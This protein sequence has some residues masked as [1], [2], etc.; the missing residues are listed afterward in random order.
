MNIVPFVEYPRSRVTRHMCGHIHGHITPHSKP[1]QFAP[2]T[3]LCLQ[4][5]SSFVPQKHVSLASLC[6]CY[7]ARHPR[8][9]MPRKRT[10]YHHKQLRTCA[11]LG[12]FR[13]VHRSTFAAGHIIC[14]LFPLPPCVMR[15]HLPSIS[16]LLQWSTLFLL[17]I[18]FLFLAPFASASLLRIFVPDDS[19]L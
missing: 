16:A 6:R 15:E 19:P 18:S 10:V 13:S 1:F 9:C 17:R 4:A 3:A 5:C 8:G 12:I 11:Y 2:R 14:L 7:V